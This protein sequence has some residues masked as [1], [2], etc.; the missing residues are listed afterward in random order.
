MEVG[1]VTIFRH[2]DSWLRSETKTSKI[3]K[4]IKLWRWSNNA[5]IEKDVLW[6]IGLMHFCDNGAGL[7]NC[8]GLIA[9][10]SK[11]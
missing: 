3:Y 8:I 2:I 11:K 4:L 1:Q 7:Y 5:M 10:G 9:L 6:G